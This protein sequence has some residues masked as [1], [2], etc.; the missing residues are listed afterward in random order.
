MASETKVP[1]PLLHPFLFIFEL[2]QW[3]IGKILSPDPPNPSTHLGRPK[4]AIIGAGITGVSSAAHCIGH[5]FDVV[6]FEAGD[7]ES[8]GGI[9]SV[10]IDHWHLGKM[11]PK[12]ECRY[13]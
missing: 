10:S 2:V 8:L 1:N 4:I 7:K 5:G 13:D 6:I 3:L 11:L 12:E 9:W